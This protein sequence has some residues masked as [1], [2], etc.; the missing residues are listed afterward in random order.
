ME[1]Q[2][3]N[4][5]KKNRAVGASPLNG[6]TISEFT[7]FRF[8]FLLFS[9]PVLAEGSGR[10]R[11]GHLGKVTEHFSMVKEPL[12]TPERR[13]KN[14]LPVCPGAKMRIFAFYSE[15]RGVCG[16]GNVVFEAR[17]KIMKY[18]ILVY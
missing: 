8:C 2:Q 9:S 1:L 14:S 10:K 13:P 11:H 5:F 17:G 18:F 12:D 15:F 6:R 7:P 3:E 4:V 16:L